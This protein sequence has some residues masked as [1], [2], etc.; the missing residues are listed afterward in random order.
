M[1]HEPKLT[2]TKVCTKCGQTKTVIHFSS[3]HDNLDGL[4][5]YCRDCKAE[6]DRHAQTPSQLA[7]FEKRIRHTRMSM[8]P[9]HPQH[10]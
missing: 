5:N 1:F 3:A 9:T 10:E 7:A 4:A 6:R 8:M 2:G